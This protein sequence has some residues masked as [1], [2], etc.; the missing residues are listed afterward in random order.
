MRNAWIFL[1]LLGSAMWIGGGLGAMFASL[2][3]KRE[4]RPAQATVARLLAAIHARIVAPG[5]AL[6]V[7]SGLFLTMT[8]MAAINTGSGMVVSPW[9][10]AMQGLGIIAAIIVFAVSLPSAT[11][12][13]RLDPVGQAA[14]FDALR[15]RQKVASMI[16]GILALV[17]LLA[18][19]MIR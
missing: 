13:A 2:A 19:A 1:H 4:D 5:A 9:L 14:A 6:T 10:M 11:R 16:M 18:G 8:Y 12:V 7:L 17:S 3:A 15:A